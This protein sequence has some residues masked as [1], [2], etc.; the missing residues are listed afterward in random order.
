VIDARD[1]IVMPGLINTHQH[2]WYTLF[3]GLAD[4]MLLEDWV[5]D[6]LLP[7][8]KHLPA[9]GMR[10]AL[11]LGDGNARDRNNLFPQPFGHDDKSGDGSI[12][13]CAHDWLWV[14]QSHLLRSPQSAEAAPTNGRRGRSGRSCR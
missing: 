1:C 2:H 4:G 5:S 8:A 13:I 14:S 3:K 7:L 12:P 9:E 6:F 10:A 11:C